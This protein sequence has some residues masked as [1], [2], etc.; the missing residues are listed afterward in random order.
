MC[1]FLMRHDSDFS[2]LFKLEL[3]IVKLSE[4]IDCK[5]GREY[6]IRFPISGPFGC[7]QEP[8]NFLI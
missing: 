1:T 7:H 8:W 4:Y 6:L 2:R 3:R 5:E